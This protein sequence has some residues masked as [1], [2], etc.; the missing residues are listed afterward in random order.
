MLVLLLLLA[1]CTFG[2]FVVVAER[3]LEPLSS[4]G[5]Y[6][7]VHVHHSLA[8]VAFHDDLLQSLRY[9]RCEDVLCEHWTT[10]IIDK[11]PFGEQVG[12]FESMRAG[13]ESVWFAYWSNR[14]LRVA[15]CSDIRCEKTPVVTQVFDSRSGAYSSIAI[16]SQTHLPSIV[17]HSNGCVGLIQCLNVS[18]S[19]FS[20][21]NVSCSKSNAQ[22]GKYP[23]IS[24]DKR[25]NGAVF[26]YGGPNLMFQSLNSSVAITVDASSSDMGRYT[27][28]EFKN[29]VPVAIYTND[30]LKGQLK[31]ASCDSWPNCDSNSFN[32]SILDPDIRGGS[33]KEVQC[34][35]EEPFSPY[36][37][38][39]S[40]ERVSNNSN[41]LIASYFAQ[42]SNKKG[43]LRVADLDSGETQTL[44]CGRCGYGR[45]SDF[46][47]GLEYSYASLLDYNQDGLYMHPKLLVLKQL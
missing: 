41:S 30:G 17:Y 2:K 1:C 23:S 22:Y 9:V 3:D 36:G 7:K 15:W 33:L 10:V 32:I 37:V 46:A 39:P 47:S 18:C 12:R 38:F 4:A 25:G 8:Y 29:N 14:G 6:T 42:T 19:S 24:F 45:D 11:H 13:N 43:C 40:L 20:S 27:A 35:K 31:R 16:D 34:T 28:S 21:S 5:Q 26:F 44:A